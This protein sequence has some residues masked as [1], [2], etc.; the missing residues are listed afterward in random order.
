MH[1]QQSRLSYTS[2]TVW[3]CRRIAF[4]GGTAIGVIVA[5]L[6]IRLLEL[7]VQRLKPLLG[8]LSPR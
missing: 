5:A 7:F 1:R 8:A 4:F 3:Q 6:G 2:L